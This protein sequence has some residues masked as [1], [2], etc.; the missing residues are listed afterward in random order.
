[1]SVFE[2]VF[3][4]RR[5]TSEEKLGVMG[6]KA[7]VVWVCGAPVE[8]VFV[9]VADC[10]D[11]LEMWL[12]FLSERPVIPVVA[13]PAGHDQAGI[14]ETETETQVVEQCSEDCKSL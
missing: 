10:Q 8:I 3:G 14:V 12:V 11:V 1:M 4:C 6:K 9:S 5:G 2:L 13:A 7:E